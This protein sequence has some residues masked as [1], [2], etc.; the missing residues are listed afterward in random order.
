ML[1]TTILAAKR[2]GKVLD[3]ESIGELIRRFVVGEVSDDQMA[4]FAMAVCIRGMNDYETAALTAAMLASGGRLPRGNRPSSGGNRPRLDKHST[5]GLGDKVSLLLAP[6][7]AAMGYDVPMISGRGLGITGGTLDKLESIDGFRTDL[8]IDEIGGV[9]DQCGCVITGAT[10]DLAPA[11]RRLYAIRDVTA[12]VPSIP[13]ITA[14]ILSKK[15]SASL[16]G[17]SM[18]VKVGSGAFMQ[19]HRDAQSLASSL[20]RVAGLHQLPIAARITDMD[21]PLGYAVGNA[22]EVAE[23]VEILNRQNTNPLSQRVEDLCVE[24]VASVVAAA[25]IDD[26]ENAKRRAIKSLDD[27]SAMER[28]EKMISSQGGKGVNVSVASSTP[29][30]SERAG[31]VES[32]DCQVLGEAVITLGGGRR[33]LGDKINHRVGLRMHVQHGDAVEPGQPMVS[34]CCDDPIDP[35]MQRAIV[36]AIGLSDQKPR[37][38]PLFQRAD[39]DAAT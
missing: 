10:D 22:I 18:D 5:G 11:D 17:L 33:K 3:E 1:T 26:H 21:Q 25:K 7:L 15:L 12:T 6:M 23:S 16:D 39:Q 8:S 28:F 29:L 27:G 38:Y 34:V 31:F 4:A 37:P 9:L 13:L 14:S 35:S 36:N 24:L 2:D 32:M 19:N 30:V 20:M